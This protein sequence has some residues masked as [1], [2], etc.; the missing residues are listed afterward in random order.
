MEKTPNDASGGGMTKNPGKLTIAAAECKPIKLEFRLNVSHSLASRNFTENIIAE[1]Q[2]DSGICG[3]GESVPRKYVTGETIE[4]VLDTS[5]R[6]LSLLKEK[7]FHSPGEVVGFLKDIG[8]SDLGIRNPAAL[9]AVELALLDLA[10]KVWDMTV[11]EIIGLEKNDE[12]L[13][14]SLVIPLLRDDSFNSFFAQAKDFGFTSVKT[15][16]DAQNPTGQ[17]KRVR[18][19]FGS[20]IEIRVDANCSWN[21]SNAEG[22]LKELHD[23]GVVSVEQPLPSDDLEG[24][25]ILR[26]KGLTLITLD[27]SV[28]SVSSLHRIISLEACDIIN[29]RISKCGG[30]LGSMNLIETALENGLGIQ[31]GAHVGESCILSAAGAHLAAGIKFFRW[32]EGCFGKYLLK[33]GLCHETFQFTKGGFLNPPKGPGLGIIIDRALMKEAENSTNC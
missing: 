2:S 15:K 16:V 13:V 22:Y 19:F 28:T 23:L 30:L 31:L 25:A 9:C 27:E 11:S 17:V 6:M 20:N 32:F 10:G 8:K 1:I 12:P 24:C 4:S 7:S 14:Y 33:K 18:D 3:F 5:G 29:I 21:R 26:E